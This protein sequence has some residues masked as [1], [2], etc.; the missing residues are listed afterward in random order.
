MGLA[1]SPIGGTRDVDV[2][3]AVSVPA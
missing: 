2:L 3:A 1:A